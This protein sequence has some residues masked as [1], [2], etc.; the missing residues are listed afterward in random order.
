MKIFQKEVIY[1]RYNISCIKKFEQN[2]HSILITVYN[3]KMIYT[4]INIR[5]SIENSDL[6]SISLFQLH[7]RHFATRRP[8]LR[9]PVV[10][11]VPRLELVIYDQR[12]VGILTQNCQSCPVKHVYPAAWGREDSGR[13]VVS[14]S[15]VQVNRFKHDP[16]FLG[17]VSL[18]I[19]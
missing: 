8:C 12:S 9:K 14:Q 19:F 10:T 13:V 1:R 15:L 7:Y 6:N 3:Q 17:K 5:W 16:C 18:M 11:M 4:V 2:V